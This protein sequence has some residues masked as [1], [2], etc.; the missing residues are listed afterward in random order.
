MACRESY[1]RHFM[2]EKFK[3]YGLTE[4]GWRMK[5][6]RKC[7]RGVECKPKKKVIYASRK[8]VESPASVVSTDELEK[9]MIW[10]CKVCD[11]NRF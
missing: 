5:Y 10:I 2:D 8:Y 3:K 1:V 4:L 6:D 11:F 9:V 7:D